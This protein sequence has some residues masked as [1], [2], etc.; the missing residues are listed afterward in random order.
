MNNTVQSISTKIYYV[1]S[2]KYYVLSIRYYKDRHRYCDCSSKKVFQ[3]LWF[4]SQI[5]ITQCVRDFQSPLRSL[6]KAPTTL[7]PAC[8]PLFKIF[9]FL[10]SFQFNPLFK[11]FQTVPPT[12]TQAAAALIQPT[13]PPWFKQ[14]QKGDFTSSTL[15]FFQKSIFILLDLFTNR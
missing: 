4:Q 1:L 10:F 13:N 2:T 3:N 5:N 11:V 15:T 6:F 14:Y 7:D 8:P 9:F 12:L